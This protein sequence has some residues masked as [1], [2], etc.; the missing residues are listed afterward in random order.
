MIDKNDRMRTFILSKI[1][2][3]I[4]LSALFISSCSYG[5]QLVVYP[6]PESHLDQRANYYIEL[7]Q[8]CAARSNEQIQL[9]ASVFHAQQGRN[10][11][12]L[13]QNK[14]VD[15]VWTLS[16]E[17]RERKFLPIRIPL[18]RGLLGWR[19]L[20]IKKRDIAR[21]ASVKNNSDL[22]GLSAGQGHDWPD[23]EILLKNGFKTSSSSSYEGL[24]AML[25]RDHI[26]YFPRSIL[27]VWP[28]LQSHENLSLVVAPTL[29]LHYPAAIY[30]FV[31]KSNVT[32]AK[33]LESC[34]ETAI[35]D[36]SFRKLFE[37]YYRSA[38][39]QANL[40]DKTVI[41]INNPLLPAATPLSRSGFWF[42]PG[43][44]R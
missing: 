27:E 5:A 20:L 31:N 38:I 8:L 4:V 3:R 13:E 30:F 39:D 25:A 33:Q 14:G 32:L 43:E 16:S 11:R 24:F 10:L 7:L 36:G 19:L 22:A 17:E 21:F 28:E 1:V 42:S 18:D 26:Q 23:L 6:L 29:V 34:L 41:R 35:T 40:S 12:L 2:H 9:Q 44:K 37:Q 15:V